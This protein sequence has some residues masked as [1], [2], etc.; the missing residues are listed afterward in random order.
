MICIENPDPL[1]FWQ[2]PPWTQIIQP[3]E[4]G[5]E[6]T[7]KTMLWLKGLPKL[8]ATRKVEPKRGSWVATTRS[9]KI[10]SKTF[11]G[12]AEAMAEQWGGNNDQQ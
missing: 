4:F 10:R 2:L 6:Y 3:Y 5:H 7:K 9:A 8:E 11:V 1:R 12:I